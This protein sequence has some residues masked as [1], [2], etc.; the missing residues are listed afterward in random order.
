M[1]GESWNPAALVCHG[2]FSQVNVIKYQIDVVFEFLYS[3]ISEDGRIHQHSNRI[4]CSS[5]V[6]PQRQDTPGL[7]QWS[8]VGLMSLCPSS[9]ACIG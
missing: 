6:M 7:G 8:F 4:M 3:I 9:G 5:Y 1:N 2:I